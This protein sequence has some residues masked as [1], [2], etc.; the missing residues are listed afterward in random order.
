MDLAEP[1]AS[2]DEKCTS[3]SKQPSRRSSQ[4]TEVMRTF[5]SK[6]NCGRSSEVGRGITAKSNTTSIG[7]RPENSLR[8]ERLSEASSHRTRKLGIRRY[9]SVRLE[10]VP[11]KKLSIMVSCLTSSA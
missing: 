9:A 3:V 4:S 6:Q 1:Y 11:K 10:D 2:D 5:V 7:S 8:T